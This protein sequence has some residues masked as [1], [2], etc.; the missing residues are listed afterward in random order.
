M[1]LPINGLFLSRDFFASDNYLCKGVYT[2]A[3]VDQTK[4]VTIIF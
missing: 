2:Y 3:L 4:D 1:G